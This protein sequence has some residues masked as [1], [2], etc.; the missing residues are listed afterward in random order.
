[1]FTSLVDRKR[2]DRIVAD[3]R[4]LTRLIDV[5]LEARP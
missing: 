4:A 2:V 1:M 5:F 3:L